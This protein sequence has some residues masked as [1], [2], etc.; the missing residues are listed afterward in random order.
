MKDK[1]GDRFLTIRIGH[2][3]TISLSNLYNCFSYLLSI[4]FA[5]SN[6]SSRYFNDSDFSFLTPVFDI[7]YFVEGF[8]KNYDI[9]IEKANELIELFIFKPKFMKKS[10][11]IFS[12]PLI[13]VGDNQV[14]F[15]PHLIEQMNLERIV[16]KHLNAF[17]IQLSSKGTNLENK[18][19]SIM[20]FAPFFK[21]NNTKVKFI[22]YDQ[23]Q[24][25]YDMIGVMG[26]KI[27]LIE[28]KC[29]TR[30]YSE[31]EI[32]EK[33]REILNGV[34]QVNRREKILIN[35]PEKVQKY[36]DIKLPTSSPTKD[37]IIKIVCTDIFDFTGRTEGDVYIT[38]TSVFMRFFLDPN[39]EQI[40]VHGEEHTV[41]NVESLY[42]EK[43]SS[44]ELIE[45]LKL[46]FAVKPYFSNLVEEPQ[47]LLMLSEHS[48]RIAFKDYIIRKNPFE[49]SS[50][51]KPSTKKIGRNDMCPCDSGKKY[52]RCCGR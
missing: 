25:E 52:K 15:C 1:L 16:E 20:N 39:F 43:P 31:Y 26:D 5:Y 21:V 17:K 13:Y 23:K 40:E 45:Y 12:Q 48:N 29:L 32:H 4:G 6:N 30:P 28:M 47:Q 9:E 33:E 3:K 44:M 7:N 19:I 18:L 11:D 35:Q 37:D 36:M 50:R 14:V 42:N 46:P 22:A 10:L 2:S 38:D 24:V 49:K 8:I 27:L 41:I 34:E 51:I